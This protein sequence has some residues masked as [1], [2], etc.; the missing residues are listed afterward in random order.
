MTVCTHRHAAAPPE[1]ARRGGR[2]RAAL[3]VAG[4]CLSALAI[5]PAAAQVAPP[6][7]PPPAPAS[8]DPAPPPP[9]PP[10]T[11]S[12][13]DRLADLGREAYKAQQYV[14]AYRHFE[15]AFVLEEKPKF[16]YNMGRSKEKLADY[17]EA[18][19]LLDRYF[20]LYHRQN[21]GQDPPDHN[22]VVRLQRE[23]KQRAFEALP[24]VSITSNPPGAQIL[25]GDGATTIG[26]TPLT[27]HLESGRYKV[28][29][30]LANHADAE[31]ELTV[32]VAGKVSLVLS[33]KTRQRRA[34]LGVWV[35]VRGVQIAID[36]KVMAVSP[37]SGKLDVEP[38]NH[39]I[40]LTR[41]GYRPVEENVTVPEDKALLCSYT[42]QPLVA[43]SSWKPWVGWPLFV[44]GAGGL[45][46]G[47][48]S[49]RYA[50]DYYAGGA[51][52]K[53]W[54]RLQNAGYAGGGSALG[55]GLLLLTLQVFDS[56]IPEEHRV[57]GKQQD[58]GKVA[59]PLTKESP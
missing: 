50:N 2:F 19:R 47:Y 35:N 33:L 45:G 24:E 58:A 44:L 11:Q 4:T 56:D 38:G 39:Q 41:Q 15:K 40:S 54:E 51:Q 57:Q 46:G 55:L 31:A 25:L 22:D 53:N 59:V 28:I 49:S 20:D 52:F 14:E 27:T 3:L 23:L 13:A 8:G 43:P 10:V 29:G 26:S 32:P 48:V 6:P 17:K 1:P 42:L 18:I 12:E 34:G 9:P 30:R 5:S 21:A 7:P 37:F 36:G 16:L